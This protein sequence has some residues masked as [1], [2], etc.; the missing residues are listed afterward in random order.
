MYMQ[1]NVLLRFYISIN[2]SGIHREDYLKTAKGILD[3]FIN[4]YNLSNGF[5]Q[6]ITPDG[7]IIKSEGMAGTMLMLGMLLYGMATGD[8]NYIEVGKKTF[9][10]YYDHYLA[11]NLAAGAALDTCC[12]DKESAGPVLRAA[13]MLERLTGEYTYLEKAENIACYLQTWMF[14]YDIKF[15]KGCDADRIELRTTGAT[16]VSVQ[17]HHLDC[18]ALFYVPDMIYLADKTG[19]TCWQKAADHLY[20]FSISFISDG[21]LKLHGMQRPVGGQNEGVF[22]CSWGSPQEKAG[23][24]NDWLVS[25][26]KTYQ[27]IATIYLMNR[28]LSTDAKTSFLGCD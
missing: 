5:P 16:S 13:L 19:N 27:L 23:D 3:F 11:Q 1:L 10:Y 14:Y 22:H 25:W 7:T 6:M 28:E 4:H 9:D 26:V 2:N 21:T 8:K 24:M 17:H 20:A 12:V 18:W 15:P